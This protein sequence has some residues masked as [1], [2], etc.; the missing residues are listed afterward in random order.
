[1]R[2]VVALGHG[3]LELN[4]MWL[5]TFLGMNSSL[6]TE[7]EKELQEKLKGIVL[8]ERGLD[9]A[10]D[11]VVKYLQSKFPDILGLDR[12]LDGMKYI[13]WPADSP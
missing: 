9:R 12:F 5:P 4:Y 3:V 6:K 2:A 8:D 11:I 7:M 13:D 1:M 10:H